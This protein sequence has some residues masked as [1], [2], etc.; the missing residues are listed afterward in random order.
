MRYSKNHQPRSRETAINAAGVLS[1]AFC[2]L[3]FV[4]PPLPPEVFAQATARGTIAGKIIDADTKEPVPGVNVLVQGTARGAVTDL[5]GNYRIPELGPGDYAMVVSMIGYTKVQRTGVKVTGGETVTI[6]FAMQP[7]TLAIGQE[8][9]VIGEKPLFQI[10]ETSSRRAVTAQDL[11]SSTLENV[12]DIVASQ[13]GVVKNN[14]ELHIRGGRAYENAFL[15]DGVS[16]QDPLAGTGF[17]LHLSSDAIEDLEVITGGINAEFGQAMSGVVNVVT[18]E[19][20]REFHGS[21][22]YK[23]DYFGANNPNTWLLGNFSRR[24][25][26]SFETDIAEGSLSGRDPLF[27]TLLP[28]LGVRLPG[29]FTFFGSGYLFFS[30]DFTKIHANQLYSSVFH[31][32]RFAPRQNNLLTGLYKLVWRLDPTHKLTFSASGSAGINQ[33]TQTLQT[34]LEYVEPE[35]GFPYDFS[36]NLDEFNTF[37]HLN[38]KIGLSWTH[39]LSPTAFYEIRLSRYFANLRSDIDGKSWS[40]Y[41]EPKQIPSLPVS[42]YRLP[43]GRVIILPEGFYTAGN[44]FTWHDHFVEDWTWRGD[45]TKTTRDGR[46]VIK[47]GIEGTYRTMQLID[48]YSPWIE[49]GFGLNN[50][51]YRVYPNQGAL[52]IQDKITFE[53]LIAN[54]GLRFDYWFPGKYVDDA[55]NNPE[56]ITISDAT[57]QKYR[58][59]TYSLGGHRWKGR[60]APRI[61]ISHPVSDNQMLFFSYGHFSKLPKPQFVYAKLGPNT[62]KSSYQKFGNPNL[63]PETTVAYE[64]GVKSQL[65]EN[66]VLTVT[67]YYKDIFDYVNTITFR[68]NTGRT[69]GRTFITYLNLDYSRARGIEAE[70]KKRIG[71]HFSAAISGAYS[72]ATGKSSSPDDGLLLA[73]GYLNERPITEDFLPWDRPWQLNVNINLTVRDGQHPKIFGVRLPDDWNLYARL[74]AQAGKRYSPQYLIGVAGDGKPLYSSDRD[75]DGDVDDPYARIANNWRWLDINFEKYFRF[76]RNQLVFMIEA[77]NVLDWK[78]TN[79]VNPVTGQAYEYGDPVPSSWNDPLYPD[80]QS[81]AEPF[82]FDP[83]R[84]LSPRNIRVGL[85]FRF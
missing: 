22:S 81:P 69:A 37:T 50:D 3:L 13:V 19:G 4:V 80:L 38:N 15:V 44:S 67:A 48:I 45:L 39:T 25:L 58:E 1:F 60:I 2:L 30:N 17:G 23:R 43:D 66:D 21:V 14:D 10:D 59:D 77:L 42:Y 56:I 6:N 83:A 53:G 34:N 32:S 8:V 68:G 31:G 24:S 46:H 84:Y 7:T 61:G 28:A 40:E 33:N 35:P 49:G 20:Q 75:Q 47:T 11:A 16:V 27:E 36:R 55:V 76:G 82:P 63:N 12:Q 79:I 18:K 9:V 54:L 71:R 41:I 64:L 62:A 85:A 72:F 51:I 26:H 29:D 73:Q 5:E 52:Y 74:F 65:S 57:R 78:N 70:Y